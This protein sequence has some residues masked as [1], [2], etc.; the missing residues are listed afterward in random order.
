MTALC[1]IVRHG[2]TFA[3]GETARRIGAATDLPLV[4]SGRAQ[5][6]GLGGHFAAQG[7][8]F[9]R[10]LASPLMRTRE[11]AALILSQLDT[12][13][14]IEPCSW[15]AEIDHGPDE[16]RTEPEVIARIGADALSAWDERGIA[17]PEWIV[18]AEARQEGWHAFFAAPPEGTTLLVTSNG[19]ARIGLLA[20]PAL[21]AQAARLPSL[22]LATGA[23]G[24]IALEAGGP[25]LVEWDRRL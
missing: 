4:E 10:V 5:A 15:L 25:R 23:Y 18:D 17:P 19:A 16:N 11:T 9:G 20:E 12:A 7:W 1:V 2:N 6:I 22:K 21:A 24:L 13:P 14:S 8:R 3:P